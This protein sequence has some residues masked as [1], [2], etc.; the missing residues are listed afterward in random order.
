MFILRTIVGKLWIT[1]IGLVVVVLLTLS[2]F[3]F[4]YI[5]TSFP[6]SQDQVDN[7]RKMAVKVADE[8][9]LHR[10]ERRYLQVVNELLSAQ[11]ASTIVIDTE[12][13]QI[14]SPVEQPKGSVLG[15]ESFFLKSDLQ[16]VFAGQIID[17]RVIGGPVPQTPMNREYTAVAVPFMNESQTQ[18]GGALILYQLTQSYEETQSYVKRLFV[19]VGVCGFL[20]TT[21]FAFFLLTKI[22]QPLQKLRKAADLISKGE[23]GTRVPITSS[24]EIGELGQTFNHMGEQL[25]DTIKALSHEKEHLASVLRSMTDA[26]ITSDA[27]GQVILTNPQGERIIRE[28]GRI[29]WSE[30]DGPGSSGEPGNRIPLP[31]QPLFQAVIQEAKEMTSK[32]HVQSEV[33]DVVMAPLYSRDVVRGVV[34]VMRDVTE[35]HRLDKLRKD[36]VANVSHELRTPLSM[37]QGYSE[38]LIDDIAASPEERKELAQVIHDESL[39]MGRLVKDLLDLAKMET[40]NI[41]LNFRRLE[42]EPFLRRIHRKFAALSKERDV[43]I[44]CSFSHEDLVLMLADEDRLEQVLTNLLDNALRHTPP[45]ATIELRAL[46]QEWRGEQAVQIDIADQGHGIPPEDLPFIFERFYKADKART[47]GASGGTGLGLSIVKNI[48]EAHDG[49]VQVKSQLGQ[50][51][52]FSILLPC[53]RGKD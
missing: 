33:W 41:E 48:V 8:I 31:M 12:F 14:N 10:E 25:S 2:L 15:F 53:K 30:P 42:V 13:M 49:T 52:T 11:E 40:G 43:A 5:E 45:H 6:K 16:K 19:V 1:I 35:E 51:T 28:W 47:R 27:D 34:A 44:T 32:L 39:R 20:M 23:Y 37:L 3:L 26:V 17:N 4:Q 24:D 22:T 29:G 9:T 7:L 18:I 38:A 46:Q 36:F 21:F 50:G